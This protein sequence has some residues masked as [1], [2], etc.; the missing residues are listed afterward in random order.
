MV[1]G[2]KK[3][4]RN[5]GTLSGG[6]RFFLLSFFL[7]LGAWEIFLVP[8]P[9]FGEVPQAYI[10]RY[11]RGFSV[12]PYA[13]GWHVSV[14]DPG[15]F[16][17]AWNYLLVSRR[18]LPKGEIPSDWMVLP[19]PL[20]RVVLLA[21]PYVTGLEDLGVLDSVVGVGNVRYLHSPALRRRLEEGKALDA[22]NDLALDLERL[23]A[24][25][26]EGLFW[27]A[28]YEEVEGQYRNL[29][30]LG[31]PLVVTTEH[32]ENHPLGRGE[33][34]VFLGFFFGREKEARSLFEERERRYR[35]LAALGAS[36]AVRPTVFGG[37]PFGDTW[38]MPG[39]ENFQARYVEDAGGRYLWED[40]P[41]SSTWPLDFEAVFS[42]AL[43]GYFWINAPN[44]SSREEALKEDS[45]YGHFRAFREGHLYTN[46]ART[47]HA[48]GNDYH[49]SGVLHPERILEDLL[50]I[51]HPELLPKHELYYYRKIPS[52]REGEKKP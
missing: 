2:R 27:Y 52:S 43:P 21:T 14:R 24:L 34:L 49:E 33:W 9:G 28:P 32:L 11:A 26:A 13:G 47:N 4:E 50:Y 37:Y 41:G 45:R 12:E 1:R 51:L 5:T 10:P 30:N 7:L 29:R 42:R 19:V 15:D 18:E 6:C 31:L 35:E 17:R 20:E 39:G 23:V 25:R 3:H 36:A 38:Y 48:G 40:L 44:W 16:T 46:G 22:G 8:F